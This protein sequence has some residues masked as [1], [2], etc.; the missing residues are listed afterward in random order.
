MLRKD[1]INQL[2]EAHNKLDNLLSRLSMSQL[3]DAKI[4][5][6]GWSVKDMLSHLSA[7]NHQFLQDIED[8]LSDRLNLLNTDQFNS[9]AVEDRKDSS[10]KEIYEE[11]HASLDEVIK[12]LKS[13]TDEEWRYQN[14][15]PEAHKSQHSSIPSLFTYRYNNK[16]HE[17]GHAEDIEKN[18]NLK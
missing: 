2:L 3:Q 1:V 11:W 8:V 17:A 18:F 15:H 9:K 14:K 6:E 4:Y 7:W 16:S 13:L 5:Q 12:R 10:Y